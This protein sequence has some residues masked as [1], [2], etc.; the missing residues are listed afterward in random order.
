LE[1]FLFFIDEFS[2]KTWITKEAFGHNQTV[3]SQV[4]N[5]NGFSIKALI[6]NRRGEITFMNLPSELE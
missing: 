1:H 6:N 2:C 3:K 4:E 5:E